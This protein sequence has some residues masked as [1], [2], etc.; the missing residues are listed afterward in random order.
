VRPPY[1]TRSHNNMKKCL[2]CGVEKELSEFYRYKDGKY[3]NKCKECKKV[4][5][6]GKI[7]K[8]NFGE[9]ECDVCGQKIIARIE[10]ITKGLPHTCSKEC[11]K[12]RGIKFTK[13]RAKR[14]Y[15][16]KEFV[17]DINGYILIFNRDHPR[18][19]KSGYVMEHR[20][21]V[22]EQIGR[23][24]T[25]EEVVHHINKNVSDNRA[26]NLMLFKNNGEHISYHRKYLKVIKKSTN[27]RNSNKNSNRNIEII[28]KYK[29]NITAI[30][31]SKEYGVTI[32]RIYQILNSN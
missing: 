26:E 16:N 23:Y 11:R 4:S 5:Q 27:N 29:N 28:N 31:L 6:K 21:V 3:Y 14:K 24:L 2:M 32:G 25:S 15:S 22:E 7:K 1:T 18:C 10:K 8:R 30:N 12:I 17:K 20:L 9:R 13:E 19:N